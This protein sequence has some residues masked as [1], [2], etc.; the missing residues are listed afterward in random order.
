MI[1]LERI[2]KSYGSVN[3]FKDFSVDFPAGKITSVLGPSG[4]GKTTI[5]KIILGLTDYTGK[6]IDQE[7]KKTFSA[8]FQEHRL[9]PWMSVH[10]NILFVLKDKNGEREKDNALNLAETAGL[11]PFLNYFPHQLS[12]GLKQRT[13]LVRAFSFKSDYLLMD[14]P[15]SHLDIKIKSVLMKLFKNLWEKD[16]RGVIM[17]TH[18]ID[19]AVE[20]SDRIYL[21]D[22]PPSEKAFLIDLNE[23][24]L[25][26]EDRKTTLFRVR[27]N[28]YEK[29]ISSSLS[30]ESD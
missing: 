10:D 17:V 23:K 5:L 2:G 26:G 14:E 16:R 6:V 24:L 3:L 27:E 7:N 12:G 11:S 20:L 21:I 4:C 29:F 30:Q 1:K 13:A 25:S 28:I 22:S 15:F 18:N 19:E 8:V 9:L